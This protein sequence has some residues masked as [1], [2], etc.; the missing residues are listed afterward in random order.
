MPRGGSTSSA[1]RPRGAAA[2]AEAR[3]GRGPRGIVRDSAPGSSSQGIDSG[4]A[5]TGVSRRRGQPA[6]ADGR[7]VGNAP[8]R[9]Q[10]VV[11]RLAGGGR[12]KAG[13]VLVRRRKVGRRR[14]GL[15]DDRRRDGPREFLGQ[16]RKTRRAALPVTLFE[17]LVDPHLGR[18]GR[19]DLLAGH[20]EELVEHAE[21]GRVPQHDPHEPLADLDGQRRMTDRE[22]RRQRGDHRGRDGAECAPGHIVAAVLLGER[23]ADVVL[24][25]RSALEQEG[26]DAPARKPLN[27]QR[28]V[29]VL[30]AHGTRPNENYAQSRHVWNDYRVP[31]VEKAT[32]AVGWSRGRPGWSC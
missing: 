2:E 24:R 19:N 15:L 25:D 12:W 3:S 31:G 30:F 4:S 11:L 16:D 9:G 26:S 20:E 22:L 21:V 8:G 6:P 10:G 17:G 29:N 23:L 14:Q 18:G 32:P 5:S 1:A 28:A 27:G 7:Q 13:Q